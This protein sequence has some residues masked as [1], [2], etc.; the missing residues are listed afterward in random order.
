MKTKKSKKGLF[1]L[2]VGGLIIVGLMFGIGWVH[3]KYPFEIMH[4]MVLSLISIIVLFSLLRL[5]WYGILKATASNAR[6]RKKAVAI[7]ADPKTHF[8]I[9]LVMWVISLLFFCWVGRGTPFIK[10]PSAWSKEVQVS[11]S[12]TRNALWRGYNASKE[13]LE[14]KNKANVLKNEVKP[15]SAKLLSWFGGSIFF[16]LCFAVFFS[17]F[18]VIVHKVGI[19]VKGGRS[20]RIVNGVSGGGFFERISRK[21]SKSGAVDWST[22]IPVFFG[23]VLFRHLRRTKNSVS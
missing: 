4:S 12:R 11:Q 20:R 2:F 15:K 7:D 9:F 18:R 3:F 8:K 16:Q 5:E 23:V 22:V 13:G 19:M 10:M 1:I 17:F 14:A 6:Q 21:V